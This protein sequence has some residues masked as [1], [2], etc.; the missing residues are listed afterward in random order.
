[1]NKADKVLMC[2]RGGKQVNKYIKKMI[3]AHTE[4]CEKIKG[5]EAREIK[6]PESGYGGRNLLSQGK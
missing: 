6:L 3:S 4:S 2:V 1:M 5:S